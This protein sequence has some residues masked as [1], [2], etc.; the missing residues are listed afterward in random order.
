MRHIARD[1]AEIV[2]LAGFRKL[3]PA[4]SPRGEPAFS[5]AP[6]DGLARCGWER[7]FGALHAHRLAVAFED[8]EA[9]PVQLIPEAE[10]SRYRER[11]AEG[12]LAHARR[13]WRAMFPRKG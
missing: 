4:L 7:F 3:S 13:F 2:H 9:E 6:G 5:S 8:G 12:A 1:R 11:P 10:A